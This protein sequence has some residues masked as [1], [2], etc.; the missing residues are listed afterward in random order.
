MAART[1]LIN[2]TDSQKQAYNSIHE[3]FNNLVDNIKAGVAIKEV[4]EKTLEFAKSKDSELAAQLGKDF[5]CGI[6]F[7]HIEELLRISSKND[8]MI[9]AGMAFNLRLT[10]NWTKEGESKSIVVAIGDTI[11]VKEDGE[12]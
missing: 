6:G 2:P 12:P 10:V 9:E 7:S 8:L 11:L 3:I 1:L 4:Y 5:G